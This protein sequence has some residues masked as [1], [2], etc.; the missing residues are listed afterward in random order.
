[1]T[2]IAY[3][4]ANNGWPDTMG[5]AGPTQILLTINQAV[6]SFSKT[7]GMADG[8][9]DMTLTDLFQPLG[10]ISAADPKVRY[11]RFT[12]RWFVVAMSIQITHRVVLAVSNTGVLTKSTVWTL[13]EF[14]AG[15]VFGQT[16]FCGVD[17]TRMGL[18]VH[19]I[20]LQFF[21]GAC[22][23]ITQAVFVIRKS[24]ALGNGPLVITGL[25][26]AGGY[27]VDNMDPS[28]TFGYLATT[29]GIYRIA[30]P[31]GTPT[32]S[33]LQFYNPFGPFNPSGIAPVRHKG[34]TR[35]SGVA[36]D[37]SGRMFLANFDSHAIPIRNGRLWYAALAGV[38]NLGN[39]SAAVRT[40]NGI[41]W[42]EAGNLN[43]AAPTV[44]QRGLLYTAS[45]ANDYDQR[46]FFIPALGLSGQGH[47]ALASSAAG[48][49]E[50]INA[51][52]AGRLATDPPGTIRGAILYTNSQAAYN[53]TPGRPPLQGWGD[54]SHISLD[55]CD[56]MTMWAFQQYHVERRPVERR[57]GADQGAAPARGRDS[58]SDG[59]AVWISLDR[60]DYHW[61][62]GRWGRIL[63][64]GYWL[65]MPTRG[66]HRRRGRREQR[67]LYES[68]VDYPQRVH[69]RRVRRVQARDDHQPGRPDGD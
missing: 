32:L 45:P 39:P 19:A 62:P 18:D 25:A 20:Y 27:P 57:G 64:P 52:V 15:Q 41:Q 11:D 31:G 24:T 14:T 5:A 6:R 12:D 44:V 66:R 16:T 34:N 1:M 51:A 22:G 53:P 48:T 59:V 37:T 9:M 68:N 10:N 8:V 13:F 40:R 28:P 23:S 21:I 58:Q 63:R 54:Y 36:S 29:A 55:P 30:D 7:T 69:A 4:A 38:D 43:A 50:Y 65:R 2:F 67:D 47:M 56:D 46:N 61:H 49:F 33:T 17:Y 35:E 60:S 42:I 26:N 3:T